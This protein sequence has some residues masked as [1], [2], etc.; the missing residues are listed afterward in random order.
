MGSSAL[1]R[2]QSPMGEENKLRIV[3]LG[4]FRVWVDSQLIPDEA[5]KRRKV[6]LWSS[7]WL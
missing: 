3:L 7:F 1:K 4:S 5:W 2:L 6:Q